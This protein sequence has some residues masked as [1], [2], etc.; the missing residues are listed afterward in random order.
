MTTIRRCVIGW[1]PAIQ[2]SFFHLTYHSTATAVPVAVPLQCIVTALPVALACFA[3]FPRYFLE[4][5]QRCQDLVTVLYALMKSQMLSQHSVDM[6]VI[7]F[8]NR[9]QNSA[10][11]SLRDSPLLTPH[12]TFPLPHPTPNSIIIGILLGMFISP[13]SNS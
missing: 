6:C 12:P 5:N 1:P 9:F 3:P 2:V 10:S 8:V 7:D 13:S 11:K 4:R